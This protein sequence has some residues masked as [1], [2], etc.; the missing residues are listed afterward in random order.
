MQSLDQNKG[1]DKSGEAD[2]K[3]QLSRAFS[4]WFSYAPNKTKLRREDYESEIKMLGSFSTVED[5]W[6]YYQHMIRPDKL[7]VGCKFALFQEGIKPVWED[8]ENQ[9]GGSFI[10]RVKKNYANKFWEDLLISYIGE[11]CD[12]NDDI[13]VLNLGVKA[14]EINIS[15]WTRALDEESREI[16]DEWIRK[17]LGFNDKIEIEY[18]HHPKGTEEPHQQHKPHHKRIE[19]NDEYRKR[20]EGEGKN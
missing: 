8:K 4:F 10:L 15:I 7:P 16:I 3:L 20:N 2:K 12:E 14:N 18:R 6:S 13:C 11:Q 5:F 1:A 19:R 9:G 17:T